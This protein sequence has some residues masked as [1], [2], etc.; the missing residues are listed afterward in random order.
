M[1]WPCVVCVLMEGQLLTSSCHSWPTAA[2]SPTLRKIREHWLFP[3]MM[4]MIMGRYNVILKIH[5]ALIKSCTGQTDNYVSPFHAL[6]SHHLHF[7]PLSYLHL[8]MD[9]PT[10]ESEFLSFLNIKNLFSRMDLLDYCLPIKTFSDQINF[11]VEI[12]IAIRTKWSIS[13]TS[14]CNN[15]R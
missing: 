9:I 10:S 2:F 3:V 8:V 14:D 7:T 13:L 5:N 12:S 4:T 11:N 1:F 15:N 6:L